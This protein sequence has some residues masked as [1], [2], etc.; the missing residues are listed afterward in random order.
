MTIRDFPA[1]ES[2]VRLHDRAE[3]YHRRQAMLD[4]ALGRDPEANET[5][6][7]EHH[8]AVTALTREVLVVRRVA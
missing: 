1:I 2:A 5:A 8:R 6:R 3:M 4:R 7:D